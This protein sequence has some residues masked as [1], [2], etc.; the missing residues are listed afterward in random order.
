MLLPQNEKPNSLWVRQRQGTSA[1]VG[2][3]RDRSWPGL[4]TRENC[5]ALLWSPGARPSWGPSTRGH[6]FRFFKKSQTC[7][8]FR[9]PS[10]LYFS[11]VNGPK[12][13]QG[14]RPDFNALCER[15]RAASAQGPAGSARSFLL[16]GCCLPCPA[17]HSASHAAGR[18]GR[19]ELNGVRRMTL[20][21]GFIRCVRLRGCRGHHLADTGPVTGSHVVRLHNMLSLCPFYCGHAACFQSGVLHFCPER[22]LCSAG[23]A[24]QP[25]WCAE[26]FFEFELAVLC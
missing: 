6:G 11:H 20:I 26:R 23:G 9:K 3:S 25:F 7:A 2:G 12:H 1:S 22:C 4:G 19:S 16:R 14:K 8:F 5:R 21:S 10:L 24:R 13:R 18:F 17:P 15:L